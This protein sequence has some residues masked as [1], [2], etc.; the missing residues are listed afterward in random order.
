MIITTMIEGDEGGVG[1]EGDED[2][3]IKRQ[4]VAGKHSPNTLCTVQSGFLSLFSLLQLFT[5]RQLLSAIL[6]S[7]DAISD[8]L[9][10]YTKSQ[11][12]P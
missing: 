6:Y 3:A 12:T 8:T 2:K 11:H 1:G 5:S 9:I 7:Y 4:A 10:K